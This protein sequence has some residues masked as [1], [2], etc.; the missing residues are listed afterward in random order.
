MHPTCV[1]S[2]VAPA[3]IASGEGAGA[4]RETS[5]DAILVAA[6]PRAGRCHRARRQTCAGSPSPKA[7]S[8][9]HAAIVARGLGLP[10]VVGVG[11]ELLRLY[12]GEICIVDGDRSIV[13]AS[14]DERRLDTVRAA[15][16]AAAA[17]RVS[18]DGVSSAADSHPRRTSRSRPGQR[19][20]AGGSPSGA[21]GGSRRRRSVAH[22]AGLSRGQALAVGRRASAHP[23]TR[24]GSA[25][26][27]HGDG[28]VC[29]TSAATRRRPSLKECSG[30]AWSSFWMIPT[31]FRRSWRRSSTSETRPSFES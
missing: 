11:P 18:S 3:G 30:V 5:G 7:E 17:A 8:P 9:R 22:R 6:G 29:S 15:M 2:A 12:E 27:A 23:R 31:R 1:A 24:P 14:P 21:R 28:P 13:I 4:D 25:P 16:T 10:M 19:G 20:D 26:R